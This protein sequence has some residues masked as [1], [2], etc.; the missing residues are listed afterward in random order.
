MLIR[1]YQNNHFPVFFRP[2]DVTKFNFTPSQ[3][4]VK[5]NLKYCRID[6][7][8]VQIDL[9]IFEKFMAKKFRLQ[10][11][12]GDSSQFLKC[13][14]VARGAQPPQSKCCFKFLS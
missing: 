8:D 13:K 5:N 4:V 14:G 12:A 11:L 3:K 10:N 2:K 1:R 6:S 9:A 7:Y